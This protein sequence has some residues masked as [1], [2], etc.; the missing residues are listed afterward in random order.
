MPGYTNTTDLHKYVGGIFETAYAD[1]ELGPNLAATGAVLLVA[2][3][4]PESE[5]VLDLPARKVYP[6]VSDAP[7]APNAT[8]RMSTDT[9]NRFWQ[10][11]VNM[12]IAMAK[13]D[14]KA[15]GSVIKVL[16]LVPSTKHLFP[17]YIQSLKDDGREELIA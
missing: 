5:V 10:G 1:P 12:T 11:K 13:G 17:L 7:T 14:V 16:K 15:E 8:L 6:S 9:A 3:H 2:C 4:D